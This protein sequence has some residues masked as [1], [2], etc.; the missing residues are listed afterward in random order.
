MKKKS[1]LVPI[2]LVS[3]VIVYATIA[4]IDSKGICNANTTNQNELK[5]VEKGTV[6]TEN[7]DYIATLWEKLPVQY[8]SVLIDGRW[9]ICITEND[10]K[11]VLNLSTEAAGVTDTEK[12]TIYFPDN[13]DSMDHSFYHE[14]AHAIDSVCGNISSSVKFKS[15]LN[16]EA[17]SFRRNYKAAY[18]YTSNEKEYFAEAFEKYIQDAELLKKY[19]PL[20]FQFIDDLT[21]KG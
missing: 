19:C 3:M 15:I 7:K 11:E 13:K 8:Q 20:T 10:L 4:F 5:I 2:I 1:L 18:Y 16:L 12:K 6:S 17:V 9:A 21:N 14:L